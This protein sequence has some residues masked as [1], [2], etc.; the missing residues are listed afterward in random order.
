MKVWIVYNS[1]D[2]TMSYAGGGSAILVGVFSSY[3]KAYEG[4]KTYY[5]KLLAPRLDDDGD[6]LNSRIPDDEQG[7]FGYYDPLDYESV[8][9]VEIEELELDEVI[10]DGMFLG[11]GA[12]AE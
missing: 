5:D 8:G 4:A 9:S 7:E 12:Y 2:V 6:N 11:G 10:V 1:S 3:E